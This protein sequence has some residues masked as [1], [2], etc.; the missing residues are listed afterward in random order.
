MLGYYAD[1]LKD[2]LVF[3]RAV[4]IR[5]DLED[6]DTNKNKM[7]VNGHVMDGIHFAFGVQA[8]KKLVL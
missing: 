7:F 8:A 2:D 1:D 5:D 6:N 3:K 4:R